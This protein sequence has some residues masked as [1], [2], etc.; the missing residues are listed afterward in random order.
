MNENNYDLSELANELLATKNEL[1]IKKEEL[2]VAQ[3]HYD[4]AS[5]QLMNALDALNVDSFKANGHSFFTA[6]K[7][8]VRIPKDEESKAKFLAWLKQEGLFDSMISVNSQTLNSLYK[9][10]AEEALKEGN[11]DFR[12]PGIDEAV[13]YKQLRIRKS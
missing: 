10:K 8:S 5:Q 1:D 6:T 4:E 3:K 9:A 12:I 11:L 7:E 2:E 13:T